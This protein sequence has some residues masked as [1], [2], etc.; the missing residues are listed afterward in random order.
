MI[1]VGG[2]SRSGKTAFA[3]NLARGCG[4]RLAYVATAELFDEEMRERAALH[5]AERGAGFTTL[6]EPHDVTGLLA[7]AGSEYDGIVVDCLTLWVTNRL[8][9]GADLRSEGARLAEAAASAAAQVV[10][11]TNEVGCGIVP[12]NEL[13]RRFRDHA[14]WVNQAFAGRADAVWWLV[15]GCPLKVKG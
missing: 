12:E 10:F 7:R 3:L 6:E 14:G 11:V 13:A 4:P 9:A 8:L 2:G 15:F 5:R 1:L